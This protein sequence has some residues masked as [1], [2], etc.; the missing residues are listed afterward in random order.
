MVNER[1][2]LYTETP[3]ASIVGRL[4]RLEKQNSDQQHQIDILRKE[5]EIERSDRLAIRST[6]KEF[7]AYIT[8]ELDRHASKIQEILN[9]IYQETVI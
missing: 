1:S 6:L 7:E 8:D 9:C 3:D 4:S 5:L 2:W